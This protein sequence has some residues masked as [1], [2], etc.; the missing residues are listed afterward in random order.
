LRLLRKPSL[1]CRQCLEASELE[2][3]IAEMEAALAPASQLS[4]NLAGLRTRSVKLVNTHFGITGYSIHQRQ[5]ARDE[6]GGQ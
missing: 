5:A 6:D 4:I 2:R 1:N 3:R